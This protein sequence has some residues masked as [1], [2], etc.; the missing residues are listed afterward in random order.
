MSLSKEKCRPHGIISS[1]RCTNILSH[2]QRCR[3]VIC[4]DC[5]EYSE[6]YVSLL[7]HRTSIFCTD[8][9]QKMQ[10]F[11]KCKPHGITS[12]KKCD[13]VLPSGKSCHQLICKYCIDNSN[14]SHEL[15]H[16]SLASYCEDCIDALQLISC[17]LTQASGN[18]RTHEILK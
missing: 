16:S 5:F 11:T 2:E 8:C 1:V 4:D 14:A 3:Q 9:I 6:S 12:N 10:Y 18:L 7:P 15:L 13:N 17:N